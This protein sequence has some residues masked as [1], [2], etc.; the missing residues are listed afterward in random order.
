MYGFHMW[1]HLFL[2]FSFPKSIN[3]QLQHNI[4][5]RQMI[6][7]YVDTFDLILTNGFCLVVRWKPFSKTGVQP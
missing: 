5:N 4:I 7:K 3:N 1:I 6:L 2:P